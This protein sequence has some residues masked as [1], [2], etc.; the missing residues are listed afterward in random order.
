MSDTTNPDMEEI[1][2]QATTAGTDVEYIYRGV[3]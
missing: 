3:N 1:Y 2:A